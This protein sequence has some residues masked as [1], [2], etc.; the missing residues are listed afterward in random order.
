MLYTES[1]EKAAGLY[2]TLGGVDLQDV[3]RA[4]HKEDRAGGG[5][6]LATS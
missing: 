2:S 5:T 6:R 1:P 4:L 3:I